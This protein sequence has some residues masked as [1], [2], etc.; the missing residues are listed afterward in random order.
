MD[1][2]DYIIVGSGSAGGVL[3]NRLSADPKNKVLL[4]EAGGSGKG[5]HHA[6]P[7]GSI[8]MLGDA[9]Y[10]WIYHAEPDPSVGGRVMQWAGGKV[11]GGSSSING[12]VYVRGTRADYD[13]WA[14]SG[15]A[16]WGFDDVLPFFRKMETF[17]GPPSQFHGSHG[18]LGVSPPRELHPSAR[19]FIQAAGEMGLPIRDDYTD[20]DQYGA[21]QA[22]GSIDKGVRSSVRRAYID[23]A[24]KRPNVTVI[25]RCT[26][27]SLILE[28]RRA[29]GVRV[30]RADGALEEHRTR[31]EVLVCCGA[32]QSPA[33][34]M[35]SGIGPAAD[36]Q[37]L[38]VTVVKDLPGV[39]GNLQEHMGVGSARRLNIPTYNVQAGPFHM[40]SHLL[41]FLLFRRGPLTSAAA[42]ALAYF[43][44][45]PALAEPDY[46]C[47]FVP[48]LI[49]YNAKPPELSD[50]PGVSIGV[51][52]CKPDARGRIRLRDAS[53]DSKPVIEHRLMDNDND[54][55]RL[56]IGMKNAERMWDTKA[57]SAIVAGRVSPP[58]PI[59]RDEDWIAYMRQI[60]GIGYHGVGTCRMGQGPDTVV[61][62]QLR[63]HGIEGLRVVDASIMPRI[64]SGNTNAPVIMIGERASDLI[65]AGPRHP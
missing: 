39:G 3:V 43:K 41:R 1:A 61:D 10:D 11:L 56:L 29:V 16:G 63:V 15:C 53:P 42:Q 7:A 23:E 25:T 40:V 55:R 30:K 13:E 37:A 62:P 44:T 21:F 54:V 48:L 31:G 64:T 59:E 36:L 14:A 46:A 60:C 34:L 38:G 26:A 4:I 45:D 52:L 58:E 51:V 24:A 22:F 35:R 2:F 9:K 20:G 50:I 6:V 28:G 27:Q 12:M 47:T 17:D 33:L 32:I 18:P 57:L 49:D 8:L 65:L 5:L 19:A